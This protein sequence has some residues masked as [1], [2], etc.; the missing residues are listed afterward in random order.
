MS[1]T[2]IQNFVKTLKLRLFQLTT[3][4]MTD[5]KCMSNTRQVPSHCIKWYASSKNKSVLNTSTGSIWFLWPYQYQKSH[6]H[7]WT[8][9]ILNLQVHYLQKCVHYRINSLP[10]ST[11]TEMWMPLAH[12][13]IHTCQN[14]RHLSQHNSCHQHN[15][16]NA[17]A[18]LRIKTTYLSL[19]GVNNEKLD[20]FLSFQTMP[21]ENTTVLTTTGDLITSVH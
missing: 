20:P 8:T 5:C 1:L 21:Q 3:D 16:T 2:S 15:V 10:G 6:S 13:K 14:H 7:F 4:C 19:N 9:V 17:S 12:S 18:P 11:V